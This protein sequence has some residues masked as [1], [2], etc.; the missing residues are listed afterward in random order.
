M[1]QF[2]YV[3]ISLAYFNTL[4]DGLLWRMQF[5]KEKTPVG[6]GWINI[7]GLNGSATKKLG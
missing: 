1:N 7:H 5:V 3:L 4:L 6:G 2:W